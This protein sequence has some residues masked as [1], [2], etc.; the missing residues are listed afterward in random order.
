MVPARALPD[1]RKLSLVAVEGFIARHPPEE[2][3]AQ[4]GI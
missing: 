4:N 3:A 2:A 1:V